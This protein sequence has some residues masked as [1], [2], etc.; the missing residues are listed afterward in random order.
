MASPWPRAATWRTRSPPRWRARPPPRRPTRRRAPRAGGRGGPSATREVGPERT[1]VGAEARDE[2]RVMV[3]A[4][5]Q[6]GNPLPFLADSVTIAVEGPARLIGP[7]RAP[8]LGGT[9]GFWLRA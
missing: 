4:L 7:P 9:T 8:L 6:A 1:T 5:D 3:R 2:V